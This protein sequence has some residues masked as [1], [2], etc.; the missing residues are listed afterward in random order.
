ML[1]RSGLIILLLSTIVAG[2]AKADDIFRLGL[3]LFLLGLGWSFT[4]IAGSA[5]LS[6]SVDATLKT[7]AQGAS[8]L[9]MNLAGAI[10]GA[11]A[12][13]IISA[14]SYGWL[15]VFAAI[16]VLLLAIWSISFKS[17]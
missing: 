15:C 17:P 5:L 14:L 2:T 8:D 1:F 10:G 16:P 3:G 11:I 6:S 4:L 7:S 13:L 9:T 12:G